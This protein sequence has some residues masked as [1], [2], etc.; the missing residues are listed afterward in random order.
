VET[1]CSVSQVG[2][3]GPTGMATNGYLAANKR[4]ERGA[5]SAMAAAA[6]GTQGAIAI[7]SRASFRPPG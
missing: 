6:T 1:T 2:C 3:H 4:V 5:L 7:I